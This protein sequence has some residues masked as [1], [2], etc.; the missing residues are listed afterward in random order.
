MI[1]SVALASLLLAQ[2]QA[3]TD[4]TTL[5][6]MTVKTVDGKS[7]KIPDPG[8]KATVLLFMLAD[9]PISNRYAPEVQRIEQEYKD[10]GIAF[11]RVYVYSGS[12]RQEIDQHTK[13]FG[14]KFPA[15]LD[16]AHNIV[17]AVGARVSPE[18]AIIAKDDTIEY[19]GRIDDGYADHGRFREGD[20][21]RDL[22]IALD[23]FLAGLAVTL[24]RT[25]ALG[26]YIE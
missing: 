4:A 10:K 18:A 19:R 24:P 13:D 16:K 23:E 21:R 17:K 22:R 5:K 3:A 6:P 20:Y 2:Q 1:A 26:C 12:T 9:C 15:V 7:A 14:Y 25:T 11:Y 8:A